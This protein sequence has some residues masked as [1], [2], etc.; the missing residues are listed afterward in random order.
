M[1]LSY[2]AE[3]IYKSWVQF[4]WESLNNKA[5]Q[6]SVYNKDAILLINLDIALWGDLEGAAH[7]N[8]R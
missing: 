5:V 7:A 4:L 1:T 3:Q 8:L 6:E 2:H